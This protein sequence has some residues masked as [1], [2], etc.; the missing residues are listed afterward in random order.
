M[1]IDAARTGYAFKL[2]LLELMKAFINKHQKEP[3][4][5]EMPEA[6]IDSLVAYTRAEFKNEEFWKTKEQILKD[7]FFGLQVTINESDVVLI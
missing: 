6:I 4:A 1:T 5:I 7:G 3:V 2:C